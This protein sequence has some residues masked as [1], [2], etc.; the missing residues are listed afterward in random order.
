[1]KAALVGL[2][3]LLSLGSAAPAAD[4]PQW[5]GPLRDGVWR[6]DG[7]V[8][9]YPAGGPR[10]LCAYPWGAVTAGRRW[11]KGVSMSWIGFAQE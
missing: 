11:R 2:V 6:E 8:A 3:C 4:W 10:V 7:L 5:F 1:M 9:K